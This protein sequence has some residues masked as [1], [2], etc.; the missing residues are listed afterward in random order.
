MPPNVWQFIKEQRFFAMIIPKEYGGL[1]FSPLASS[2]VLGE[3]LFAQWHGIVDDRRAELARPGRAPA[4]LRHGRAEAALAA[5]ARERRRDPVLRADVAAR[6]LRRDGARRYGRRLQG[7]VGRP[8]DRRHSAQLGQALHHA[9]A[10]R[11][12]ARSRVQALRSRASDRRGRGVRHHGRADSDRLARH[13]DRPAPLP[14]QHSVPERPHA[15]PRRVRAARRDHRR[16]EDGGSRLAHARAAACRRPQHR[17]AV[18]RARRRAGG[19]LCDGRVRE[20]APPVQ[21]ADR[22]VPRRR[23][24]H[25]AHGRQRLHDDGR[26]ASHV[27]GDHERARNPPCRRRS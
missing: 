17:V 15:R 25:R 23:R 1:G 24:G 5:A 14:D 11:D 22:Q 9:R 26:V 20:A 21:P 3:D 6:R 12:R 27:H 4:P 16:H 13:R 19:R 2:M 10:D 8:R 7:Q 18:Q